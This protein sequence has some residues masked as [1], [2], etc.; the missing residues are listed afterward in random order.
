[1]KIDIEGLETRVLFPE[2]NVK[3][4]LIE[5]HT[6]ANNMPEIRNKLKDKYSIEELDIVN[7]K[8]SWIIARRKNESHAN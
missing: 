4:Y 2:M 6:N 1:M 8:S 3:E 5:V 7:R